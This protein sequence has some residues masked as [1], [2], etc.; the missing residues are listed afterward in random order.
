MTAGGIVEGVGENIEFAVASASDVTVYFNGGST[1][2]KTSAD[3]TVTEKYININ[4]LVKQIALRN[5]QA[6]SIVSMNGITFTDPI[7]IA[8]NKGLTERLDTPSIF[9]MVIRIITADTNIK[10]RVR[11]R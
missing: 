2:A 6:I 4:T 5:S 8:A 1:Q 11:G 9:M 3:D 10:I 7:S